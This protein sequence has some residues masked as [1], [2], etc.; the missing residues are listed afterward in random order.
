MESNNH[1]MDDEDF[2]YI[3]DAVD[4]DDGYIYNDTFIGDDGEEYYYEE[5]LIS[6]FD[7]V[8]EYDKGTVKALNGINLDIFEGEFVSIIGPSGSGKSTLLNM[9]GA[10]DK[11]T[12]GKI[13]IDGIDLVREKDLSE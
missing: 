7:V 3:D 4:G 8:K 5:P 6:L 11:P 2:I 10:L 12:I 9:L 1:M 13:F